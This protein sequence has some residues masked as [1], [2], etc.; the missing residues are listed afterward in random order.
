MSYMHETRHTC[1]VMSYVAGRVIRMYV[2]CI[3]MSRPARY[4]CIHAL[5]DMVVYKG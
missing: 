4:G 1:D 2:C 3:R 5:L